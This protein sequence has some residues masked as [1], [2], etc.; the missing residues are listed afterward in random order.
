MRS[1]RRR[2][3]RLAVIA[4]LAVAAIAIALI[5]FSPYERH[6][7]L[8]YRAMACTV[9][10]D[11]A[12]DSLFRYLGNSANAAHW[13]VFPHHISLL[14]ADSVPDGA[15]G[16]RRRSFCKKD[17]TGK[18]WDETI[19]EAVPGKKRKLTLYDFVGFAASTNSLTTEQLYAPLDGGSRCRLTFTVFFNVPPSWRE[20]VQLHFAAYQ[21]KGIFLRNMA[22]IKR[23]VETGA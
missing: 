20:S 3:S 19:I 5:V 23:L 6:P 12:P 8:G 2:G 4:P 17:E 21:I 9:D 14:N 22:N 15:P 16:S 18:R 11:A 1:E 13:S 7:E 10:I